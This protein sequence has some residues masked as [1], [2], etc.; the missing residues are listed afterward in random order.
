[1]KFHTDVQSEKK[2]GGI[3][4]SNSDAEDH[5]GNMNNVTRHINCCLVPC[6]QCTGLY[7]DSIRGDILRI[8]CHHKCHSKKARPI[9]NPT[10]MSELEFDDSK[11][12][13][14]AT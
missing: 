3:L 2:T 1:M 5:L 4:E 13:M 9:A 14:N 12:G 8:V 11:T 7:V 6:N 10:L